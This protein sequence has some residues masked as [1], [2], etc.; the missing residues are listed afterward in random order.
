MLCFI[1]YYIE[2]YLEVK[3]KLRQ[4]LEMVFGKDLK[5]RITFMYLDKL[6]Y[7]D[8][9]IKE[10]F[11]HFPVVFLMGRVNSENDKVREYDWQKGTEFIILYSAIMKHKDYW[12]DPEKF[13]P[14]RFYK[15]EE[16][17]KYLLERQQD[18]NCFTMWGGGTRICPGRKLATIELKC[19]LASI[20]RKYDIELVDMDAPIKC[21]SV[22]INVIEELIVKIKPRKV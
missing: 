21:K 8:A 13:D 14:D 18:K 2:H 22:A 5:K 10:V 17:D 4:E 15:V 1:I 19:L 16:S 6:Q 12:T 11:R 7:C 3:Q 20:Y 9:V